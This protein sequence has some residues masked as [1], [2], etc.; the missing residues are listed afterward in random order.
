MLGIKKNIKEIKYWLQVFLLPLYWIS[1]LTPRK[2]D[3]WLFGSTFGN[4]FADNPKYLYL[5]LNQGFHDNNE[6][7]IRP[8][9][10]SR[11]KQIVSLLKR[12]KLEVYYKFSFKAILFCLI[13]KVYIFDNYSKDISFWLSGG[14]IKVNLWHGIPLKKINHDN[15]FDYARNPRNKKEKFIFALRTLS[16]EKPEHYVLTTSDYMKSIFESAFITKNIIVS[17]YPRND[18]F[19][20]KYENIMTDFEYKINQELAYYRSVNYGDNKKKNKVVLYMPTFRDSETKFF[21]V[22]NFD[23]LHNFLLNNN[24]LFC[25]KL[26]PKSKLSERLNRT[27]YNKY[28]NFSIISNQ[29][30]PYSFLNEVD[31]L[32]TD[33]SSIYFDFLLTNRPIIFFD[34]DREEYLKSSR[35]LYFEY[36][37]FT[38]G[39]KVENM[40]ELMN[41]LLKDDNYQKQR[42]NIR[43]LIMDKSN[44]ENSKQLFHDLM[45]TLYR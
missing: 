36:D 38:P 5:Y 29:T 20:M 24:V 31:I 18:C 19:H 21:D 45:K 11:N 2:K 13:G 35:E 12:H 23:E 14:A 33:Y 8:I 4:R 34:Y 42:E 17:G 15:K 7:K 3:I 10:I 27:I 41:A 43:K 1:F 40:I 37:K 32:I 30:D 16:D 6:T 26:H 39:E 22:I 25:F 9:W 44:N 28:S